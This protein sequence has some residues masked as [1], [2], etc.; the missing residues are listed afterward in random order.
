M[1]Q[2]PIH[3]MTGIRVL[4]ASHNEVTSIP[5]LAFPKLYELHTVDISYNNLTDI[6]NAVFQNLFSLR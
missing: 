5:K 3:N 6:N 2:I 1:F 4:N